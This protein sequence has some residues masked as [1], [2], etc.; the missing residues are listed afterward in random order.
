MANMMR[1][2]YGETNPVIIPVGADTAIEI[3]DLVY[4]DSGSGNAKPAAVQADQ[5]SVAA[6]QQLFHTNFAGIAMQASPSGDTQSIRVATTGVFQFDCPSNTFA[7]GALV[8]AYEP[9]G[10]TALESQQ[11]AGVGA[12]NL[13]I[14]RCARAVNP[15]DVSV[16]V[17][18]V[19]TVLYGGPQAAA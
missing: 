1:W 2:R 10:G 11:V 14:G 5:G 15:A 16:L 19:S 9:S 8:G 7:L 13:A 12:A 17:D 6:N 3:G 18:I 4:L